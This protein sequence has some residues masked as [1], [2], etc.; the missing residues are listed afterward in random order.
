MKHEEQLVGEEAAIPC[1]FKRAL[2][3]GERSRDGEVDVW[4]TGDHR[5][6]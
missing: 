3:K 2:K 6:E 5:V 4:Q 1:V